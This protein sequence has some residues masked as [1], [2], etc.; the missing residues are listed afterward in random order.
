MAARVQSW[1]D[2]RNL[3]RL[4]SW[5]TAAA[6]AL[7]VAGL[8]TISGTGSQR[9]AVAEATLTGS[10]APAPVTLARSGE[11][12]T[13]AET[14]RL[15]EA[16]RLLAADRDR[17]LNRVA[18]LERNV[19]DITGSI[20]RQ[21]RQPPLPQISA[22]RADTIASLP[23]IPA[24]TTPEAAETPAAGPA[25]APPDT[26]KWL[27]DSPRAWPSKSVAFV[28]APMVEPREMAS[29]VPATAEPPTA[30]AATRTTFGVDIGGGSNLNRIRALWNAARNR[31]ARLFAGLHPVVSLRD[32]RGGDIRLLVGPLDDAGAAASLCARL[33]AAH[34]T[35]SIQPFDGQRLVER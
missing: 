33:G 18:S 21:S 25:R 14:R 29:A 6:A 9:I 4:A 16:I 2:N 23:Q 20:K 30:P 35:C 13:E 32:D 7:I 8:A 19:D 3:I 26:P 17:L 11:G 10:R 5:G 1:F 24:K 31:H 27:T 28:M 22:R 12:S 34:V 15:N